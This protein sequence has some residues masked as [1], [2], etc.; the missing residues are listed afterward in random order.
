MPRRPVSPAPPSP[1]L[2]ASNLALELEEWALIREK[3]L[4]RLDVRS[5]RKARLLASALRTAAAGATPNLQELLS[6]A[7]A[8]LLLVA[9]PMAEPPSRYARGGAPQ[10]HDSGVVVSKREA[11]PGAPPNPRRLNVLVVDDDPLVRT[12]MVRRLSTVAQVDSVGCIADALQLLARDT[13]DVVVSDLE[14]AGE[15]GADLLAQVAREHPLTRR[16][17]F[18][19]TPEALDASLRLVCHELLEKSAGVSQLLDAV[20][21]SLVDEA[22]GADD[23]IS[24]EDPTPDLSRP[25]VPVSGE[26]VVD[27]LPARSPKR[28]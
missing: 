26:H 17:L 7:R 16:I 13:Y 28:R 9:A 18:T 22:R 4:T 3:V 8:L 5:A 11:A 19:G 14:L 21:P 15:S 10:G 6:E 25:G 2:E 12:L 20:S 27:D 23:A 24:D 1:K